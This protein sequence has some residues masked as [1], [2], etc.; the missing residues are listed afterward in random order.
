MLNFIHAF[1]ILYYQK[2]DFC[3]IDVCPNIKAAIFNINV[4]DYKS[5][6]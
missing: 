4:P 1:Y 5:N 2:R 3:H 6:F